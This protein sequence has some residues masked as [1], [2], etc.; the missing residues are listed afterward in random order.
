MS[1]FSLPPR[2][3]LIQRLLWTTVAL[4]CIIFALS[5][6]LLGWSSVQLSPTCAGLTAVFA[7]TLLGLSWRHNTRKDPE[8]A[9]ESRKSGEGPQGSAVAGPLPL[10][11]H[12][13]LPP[14]CRA[15]TIS[16]VIFL[17]LPWLAAFGTSVTMIIFSSSP[18]SGMQY[19]RDHLNRLPATYIEMGLMIVQAAILIWLAVLCTKERSATRAKYFSTQGDSRSGRKQTVVIDMAV[20]NGPQGRLI[21]RLIMWATP[22][23]CATT[24]ALAMVNLGFISYFLAPISA[25]LTL[26]LA[27]TVIILTLKEDKARSHHTPSAVESPGGAQSALTPTAEGPVYPPAAQTVPTPYNT[28]PCTSRLPTIIC[29]LLLIPVW[30]VAFATSIGIQVSFIHSAPDVDDMY[31]PLVLVAESVLVG[32]SGIVVACFSVLCLLQRRRLLGAS[33]NLRWWQLGEYSV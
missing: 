11:T 1:R 12:L 5:M 7:G 20:V 33:Q 28:L 15:I 24:F 14:V 10:P 29:G 22:P 19:I 25:V 26:I 18:D 13:H 27:V 30:V 23:L 8:L 9:K 16:L 21:R 3:L 2:P 32:I 4:C 6:V 17:C 31:K